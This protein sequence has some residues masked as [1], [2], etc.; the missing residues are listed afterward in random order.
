LS[1]IARL[2]P[3]QPA[4]EGVSAEVW[5]ALAKLS[6]QP[7][8]L[9]SYQRRLIATLKDIGCNADGAPYVITGI[10]NQ[11][12][13]IEGL[14]KG[15]QPYIPVLAVAFLDEPNCAGAR[16]LSEDHKARLRAIRDRPTRANTSQANPASV[17]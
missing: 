8:F 5:T 4:P 1:R 14:F 12:R 13:F 11:G 2:N 15:G 6:S 10:V 7:D 9:D 3:T 17:P 16:G